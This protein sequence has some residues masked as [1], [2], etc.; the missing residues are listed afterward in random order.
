MTA[1]EYLGQAYI[2]NQSIN[3]KII[4]YERLRS[5]A[6]NTVGTITDMP[7]SS[8]VS[9][10]ICDCMSKV[11]DLD[12]EI[13]ADIDRL[14]KLKKEMR[15][16]INLLPNQKMRI[17]LIMRYIQFKSWKDISNQIGCSI[18]YARKTFK[19]NAIKKFQHVVETY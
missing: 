16:K 11:I 9:D 12:N 1:K 4:K 2:L 7:H 19:S 15:E 14:A 3:D 10:K 18:N 5:A 8:G 6:I 17:L 13:N